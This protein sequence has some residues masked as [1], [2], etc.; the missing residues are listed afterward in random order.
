M[1]IQCI[2]TE[3]RTPFQKEVSACENS[4]DS[5]GG[6]SVGLSNDAPTARVPAASEIKETMGERF[7]IIFQTLFL[8]S[9]QQDVA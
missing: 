6:G 4:G 5:E 7:V 9:Y 3:R 2:L 8:T 1:S